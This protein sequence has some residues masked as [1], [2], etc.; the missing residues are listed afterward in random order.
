[1]TAQGT[2]CN[3]TGEAPKSEFAPEK[4]PAA[5]PEGKAPA[6]RDGEDVGGPFVIVNG[7]SDGLSDRGS[8][9]DKAPGEDSPS[10][11][12][13]APGSNAAPDAP[14]GGDHGAADG[15]TSA[16]AAAP[17]VSSADVCDHAAEEPK[18]DA[19][20]DKSEQRTD[21]VTAEVVHQETAGGEQGGADAEL[22]SGSDHAVTG[23]DSDAPAVDSEVNGKEV[24]KEDSSATDVSELVVDEATNAE[25][26]V[27][28]A[29]L[30]SCGHDDALTM[31]ESGSATIESE[32]HV[33]DNREEGS[34]A[35]EVE[36]VDQGTG[37]SGAQV[38]NGHHSADTKVAD[39]SFE[40]AA[41][42][43]SHDDDIKSE[44]NSSEI[45]VDKEQ[46][47]ACG[48]QNGVDALQ[49]NGHTHFAV[50]SDSSIVASKSE[51]HANGTEGQE[52]DQQEGCAPITK[53]VEEGVVEA[54]DRD[55]AV[56]AE[57][58][59]EEQVDADGHSSPITKTVEEGVVEAADRDCAVS[60]EDS[61]EEQVDA[62]GHSYAKVSTDASREPEAVIENVEGKA[63]CGILQVEEEVD[64]D[65]EGGSCDDFTAAVASNEEIKLPAA[66]AADEAVPGAAELEDATGDTSQDIVHSDGLVKDGE[67]DSSVETSQDNDI[68]V[69]IAQVDETAAESDLKNGSMVEVS[70][71]APLLSQPNCDSVVE[72]VDNQDLGAPD[73]DQPSEIVN[74]VAEAEIMQEVNTEVSAAVPLQAAAASPASTSHNETQPTELIDGGS[75]KHSSPLATELESCDHAH[76]E[77][78]TSRKI[79]NTT[80]DQ[81]VSDVV[82][83]HGS[84]VVGQ[85]EL[86][87]VIGDGSLGKP[88]DSA[89]DDSEPVTLNADGL[90]VADDA[91]PSSATEKGSAGIDKVGDI[92]KKDD[93]SG[94]IAGD[95]KFPEDQS[96]TCNASTA[97]SVAEDSTSESLKASTKSSDLVETKCLEERQVNDEHAP[98]KEAKVVDDSR[99]LHGDLDN[100]NTMGDAQVIR[101]QKVYIIK[102]PRFAGEDLWAKTQ[103]AHVRL[104]QLT[105]ERDAINI[106]K[107]KQKSVC[108]QYRE[109]L[110]AARREERE[111]RAAHGDKKNDLNSVRSVIGKLNQANSIEE[112]EEMIATKERIMQHETISLKEEKLLI[113]EINDLKAQR[114]QLC[115]NMGSK[116]EINEAFDQKEHIHERH[117]TLKKDSDVLFTNLKSLEENTRKIQKSFEDERV[118]FRKLNDE[119][120]VA[121]ERRQKAYSDW[122]ELK[123]E[124]FKKNKYFFM[125]K[126]DCKIADNHIQSGD[127][128]QLQLYCNDQVE[129][130]MEMW[131]KDEDFRKQY[132]EGNK[133]ST[134]KRFGTR[135]GRRLG[136]DE[137]PPLIPSRRT[138]NPSPSL[139]ASSPNVPTITTVPAPAPVSVSVK[140][141]SFPV[142][143]SPDISK[144]AK[145]KASGTSAQ[146]EKIT[147]TVSERDVKETEKEKARL[148]E[149]ELERAKKAEELAR[150]EQKLREE[151]A[152]AEKERLRLEQKA[153]AKEAEERKRRK[154]E[155]AQERAEFKARKE[156]EMKEKKK[157]KKDKKK[158]QAD[159]STNGDSSAAAL[160]TADTDSN[161]SDNPREVEIPQPTAPKR[162]SRPAAAIKQL[163][164]LDPMPAPL[165]NKGKRK[166]RQYILIAAAVL[167]VLAL[168][169]AGN[170]IPRLKSLH[171]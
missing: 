77:E 71:T 46:S 104:D 152:A 21:L 123:A 41:E 138:S 25:Q 118:I 65:G 67:A 24:A 66:D 33:D 87:S 164:R 16:S 80:A 109:K 85:A 125:Y 30:E 126:D 79:S 107:Q 17:G 69:E 5:A 1:M 110:E 108:D 158:G 59:A 100:K 113:K 13:E 96:E 73:V 92:S 133:L 84:T 39:D 150:M 44:Q 117:K 121:N 28:N 68:Q 86:S 48:E 124:P 43:Q 88:N 142:L 103:E 148:M 141:D 91:E 52:T 139:A 122:A 94:D 64:K 140:E 99:E 26:N 168:F 53:T 161:A 11:E 171:S 9:L 115:S 7:D 6:E 27:E 47:D 128:H 89:L 106:R 22:G 130:V 82:L 137:E 32:V 157:A 8:D 38:T 20:D 131:N 70:T 145:S 42:A 56:S 146:N 116:A 134:L 97:H 156:A 4:V 78:S 81:L 93:D 19:D 50:S 3:G 119:Y 169:M 154:A 40:V 49:T 111:A 72:T 132:V 165:R 153:K 160:T 54:A 163:N 15:E 129:R 151:K 127:V 31:A 120:R 51:V 63:T 136:P 105:Q 29:G 58:S 37:G 10:E 34:P 162:I 76:T 61:A 62:D 149:E 144:H 2:A 135:D 55:C 155:K 57:Y 75:F 147:V 167:S 14:V 35:T 36:S 98:G 90:I 83:E 95:S 170:Y 143:P 74:D 45:A 12:D 159:S 101:Q 166:M 102:V 23:A 112:I 60:A 18:G 114:K